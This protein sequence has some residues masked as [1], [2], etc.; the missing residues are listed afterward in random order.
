MSTVTSVTDAT[1]EAE[2][3]GSELPVVVDIWA[4]WCGPC[5]AIAPILDQLA[6]EYADRVKIVKVDA[7]RNPE[8]VTAVGVTSIPTLGFYRN[9]ERVGVLIGAHPKPVYIAKFEEMLA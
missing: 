1:F 6:G 8:T 7:D 3:L 4:A 9:G 2:V 5:K